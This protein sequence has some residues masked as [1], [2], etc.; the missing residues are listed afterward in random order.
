[1]KILLQHTLLKSENKFR[2]DSKRL[3]QHI[4]SQLPYGDLVLDDAFFDK[5]AFSHVVDM[6]EFVEKS[7]RLLGL[8]EH[9]L[10]T[11]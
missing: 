1:M 4:R 11:I 3:R 6:E 8:Y 7:Q 10:E 5:L 9:E 2:V